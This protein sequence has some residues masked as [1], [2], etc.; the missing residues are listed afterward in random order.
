MFPSPLA[1]KDYFYRK[2]NNATKNKDSLTNYYCGWD[3][4]DQ[5]E[6][7]VSFNQEAELVNQCLGKKWHSKLTRTTSGGKSALFYQKGEKTAVSIRYFKESRTIFDRWMG[8]LYVGDE[9]SL[10][11]KAQ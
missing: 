5:Q 8:T 11:A 2:F 1:Y 6:A 10:K 4:S 7:K 3:E 9:S